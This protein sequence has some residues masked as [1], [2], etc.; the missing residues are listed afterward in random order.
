MALLLA[1]AAT[2]QPT[3][4][5]AGRWDRSKYSGVGSTT[6]RSASSASGASGSRRRAGARVRYARRG[7]DLYV[8]AERYR[9]LVDRAEARRAL[10]ARGLHHH[11]PAQ[12]AQHRGLARCRGVQQDA[13]RRAA[14]NVARAA[15]GRRRPAGGAGQRKVAGAALDVFRSEPMT[16]HPLF[17]YPNDR[18]PALGRVHGEATDRAGEQAAEQVVAALTGGVVSTAV[19]IPAIPPED[20]E[21]VGL[22]APVRASAASARP[23]GGGSI[24]RVES[25]SGPPRRPRRPPAHD[26]RPQRRPGRPHRGGGQL[27]QRAGAGRGARDRGGRDQGAGRA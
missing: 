4:R 16:D 12:H 25:S 1:L 19:N 20:R 18:D 9:D 6:R 23:R 24:D 15:R 17:A 14:L 5:C 26:R 11:P 8:G 2:S 22:P 13:R 27:R 10:R 21:A 3:R 7:H